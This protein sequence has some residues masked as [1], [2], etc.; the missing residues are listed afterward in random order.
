M[1]HMRQQNAQAQPPPSPA[2][3]QL[4][5]PLAPGWH[6]QWSNSGELINIDNV[7]GSSNSKG[8]LPQPAWRWPHACAYAN[9]DPTYD[10]GVTNTSH[11]LIWCLILPL[12]TNHTL[13]SLAFSPSTVYGF[14]CQ[15]CIES[16]YLCTEAVW[17]A[18]WWHL[19]CLGCSPWHIWSANQAHFCML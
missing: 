13:A 6:W 1:I 14:K 19:S 8:G 4:P 18:K 10:E 2:Q 12:A 7:L 3:A 17:F 16:N 9:A 15:C 5:S 11:W